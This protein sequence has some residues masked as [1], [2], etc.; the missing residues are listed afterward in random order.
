M[1]KIVRIRRQADD[2]IFKKGVLTLYTKWI[3]DD[4][5][6]DPGDEVII[7]TYDRKSIGI[8]IYDGIEPIGVRILSIQKIKPIDE[9][10]KENILRAYNFRRRFGWNSFRL[11]NSDSDYMPGLIID[12]YNDTA[13][14]QSGSIGF[15]HYLDYIANILTSMNIAE[16]VYVKNTQRS[17]REAGLKI[18]SEWIRGKGDFIETIKEGEAIFKIDIEKGQKTG[19]FLD[20]RLNRL[21]IGLYS[22]DKEVLD[23]FSYSGGFG[24]HSLLSGAKKVVF[25]EE[26]K[27]AVELLYENLKLNNIPE[28]N[29]RIYNGRVEKFFEEN[30][31]KYDVIISDPPAFIQSRSNIRKG[32]EKYI[33]ILKNVLS[34]SKKGTILF[35]SSCSYFLKRNKFLDMI[36]NTFRKLNL[37]P[38]YMGGIRGASP[39][40]PHRLDNELDYLK[41]AYLRIL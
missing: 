38:L 33:E 17:R 14:I 20:Q 10:I 34:I 26:D 31:E 5:G 25:V 22:S 13:V 6:A 29:V 39:D 37:T 19:F 11:I 4:G 36:E 40:H 9:V 28:E 3:M 7:E 18:W 35:F 2:I 30:K 21:E 41:A 16:K 8:G 27:Y 24:I 15:D 12:I 1:V 32:T 23:L